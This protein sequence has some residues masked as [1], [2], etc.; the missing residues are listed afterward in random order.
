VGIF[1]G[2]IVQK[3]WLTI[4]AAFVSVLGLVVIPQLPAPFRKEV[5]IGSKLPGV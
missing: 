4:A 3:R 2:W 1:V 5:P